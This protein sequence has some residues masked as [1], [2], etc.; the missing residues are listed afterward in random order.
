M[1][2]AIITTDGWLKDTVIR[3]RDTHFFLDNGD[4]L[5]VLGKFSQ[6]KAHPPV[7]MLGSR[8]HLLNPDTLS[9]TKLLPPLNCVI[10]YGDMILAQWDD[11]NALVPLSMDTAKQLVEGKMAGIWKE[12]SQ[13]EDPVHVEMDSVPCSVLGKEG[14]SAEEDHEEEEEA[15]S[16]SDSYEGYTSSISE[17]DSE[18][19]SSS[20]GCESESEE[21][22]D[23]TEDEE[24]EIEDDEID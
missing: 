20:D 22:C 17:S 6:S 21:D 3:Y 8:K 12:W 16:D 18:D 24:V 10:P 11:S 9:A 7:I 14:E 2:G 15:G 1:R 19:S 5:Q 23:N 13:M 4:M